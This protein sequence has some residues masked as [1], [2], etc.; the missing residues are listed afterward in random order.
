MIQT[1]RRMYIFSFYVSESLTLRFV[2]KYPLRDRH[3]IVVIKLVSYGYVITYILRNSRYNGTLNFHA[4]R[5]KFE[6]VDEV[7]D[8]PTYTG[9]HYNPN[10]AP[11]VFDGVDACERGCH[12]MLHS[13]PV[14][15]LDS[16]VHLPP[17]TSFSLSFP[18]SHSYCSLKP[19]FIPCN[20]FLNATTQSDEAHQVH[21]PVIAMH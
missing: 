5:F 16:F 9:K 21:R 7:M 12:G 14:H 11:K 20:S 4:F 13:L 6:T 8:H 17:F 2:I 10:E 19:T 18:Q 15:L 3:Y 1:Q